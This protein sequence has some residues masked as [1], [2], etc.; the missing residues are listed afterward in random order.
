MVTRRFTDD[1]LLELKRLADRAEG[2]PGL[3][4]RREGDLTPLEEYAA[5]MAVAGPHLV[6]ELRLLMADDWIDAAATDIAKDP[7]CWDRR[8]PD[9]GRIADLIRK[10][11]R[12]T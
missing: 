5:V 9:A 12:G 10:H 7:S 11:V 2:Q 4:F 1:E 6:A 3:L 8:P